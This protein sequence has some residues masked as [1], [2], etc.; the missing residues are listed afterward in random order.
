M[1]Q[2]SPYFVEDEPGTVNIELESC[3]ACGLPSD[4]LGELE[5]DR[6]CDRCDAVFWTAFRAI[7]RLDKPI[8]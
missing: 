6:L 7:I 8:S 1:V 5:G 3:D 4:S 2:S